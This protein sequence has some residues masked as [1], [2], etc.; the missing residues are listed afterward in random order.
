MTHTIWRYRLPITDAPAVRMPSDAQVLSVGPP[1]GDADVLDMW[2]LVDLN[3]DEETREFR[4]V[5]TGHPLPADAGRFVGT[6]KSH[7]GTLIWHV[8]EAAEQKPL[9]GAA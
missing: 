1:R 7:G 2:V 3:A 6:T 4:I 8:F 5:G 9:G